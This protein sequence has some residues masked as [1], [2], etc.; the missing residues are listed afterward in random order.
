MNVEQHERIN[1]PNRWRRIDDGIKSAEISA[2]GCFYELKL[3]HG[4]K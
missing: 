4:V 3:S 2:G 1:H